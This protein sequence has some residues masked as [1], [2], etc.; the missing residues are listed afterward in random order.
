MITM[1][2]CDTV[3]EVHCPAGDFCLCSS[4]ALLIPR[5]LGCTWK[6]M[7][8]QRRCKEAQTA[9]SLM[10]VATRKGL[11]L[12]LVS[13]LEDTHRKQAMRQQRQEAVDL[14]QAVS[15]TAGVQHGQQWRLSH[16]VSPERVLQRVQLVQRN[17]HET[18]M[19]RCNLHETCTPQVTEN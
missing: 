18:C 13:S 4:Q 11:E 14:R 3:V 7:C 12:R 8:R 1:V 15:A 19:V 17:M 9:T 6:Q 5:F 2:F 16:A 10:S